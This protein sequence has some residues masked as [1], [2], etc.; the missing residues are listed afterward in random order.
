M[1]Y[2]M[3]SSNQEDTECNWPFDVQF[4]CR[5]HKRKENQLK[6]QHT[7]KV[8][9]IVTLKESNGIQV[10]DGEIKIRNRFGSYIFQG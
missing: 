8:E 3:I 1:K 2:P 4:T 5:I 6:K 7:S 10:Y 9:R